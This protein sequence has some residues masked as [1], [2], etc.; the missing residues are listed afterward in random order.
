MDAQQKKAF[1][2]IG[3]AAAVREHTEA[4]GQ[5]LELAHESLLNEDYVEA[6]RMAQFAKEHAELI[7]EL[8]EAK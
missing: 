6:E 8:R 5:A 2:A 3:Q 4:S 1:I 7:A